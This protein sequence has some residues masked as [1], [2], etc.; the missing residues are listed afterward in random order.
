MDPIP[1]TNPPPTGA[2]P[3]A[4]TMYAAAGGAV[5]TVVVGLANSFGHPLD[6][7]TATAIGVLAT[8]AISY[9]HPDGRQFK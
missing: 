4:G 1:A 7:P 9:L 8:L 2:A 3:T 5:A 6:A